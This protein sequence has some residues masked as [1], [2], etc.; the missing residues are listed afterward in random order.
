[1]PLD[2][3]NRTGQQGPLWRPNTIQTVRPQYTLIQRDGSVVQTANWPQY[4]LQQQRPQ[5]LNPGS[6]K[7]F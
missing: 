7:A 4:H 1:M 6:F 5:Q 3:Q 2:P